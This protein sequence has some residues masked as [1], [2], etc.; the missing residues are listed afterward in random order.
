MVWT[1]KINYYLAR[2]WH[3]ILIFSVVICESDVRGTLRLHIIWT[4]TVWFTNLI[5][6]WGKIWWLKVNF[7]WCLKYNK[8]YLLSFARQ[9]EHEVHSLQWDS[10][11]NYHRLY[12]VK[13]ITPHIRV[14]SCKRAFTN[15]FYLH[16]LYYTSLII[17]SISFNSSIIH[18]FILVLI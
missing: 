14:A 9:W 12:H 16:S 2:P 17:S 3:F 13:S 6:T 5:G 7:F 11:D 10:Y 8:N 18:N 1:S 15:I 4:Q